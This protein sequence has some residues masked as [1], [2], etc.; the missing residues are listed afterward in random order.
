MVLGRAG[1]IA[2]LAITAATVE[3]GEDCGP[4]RQALTEIGKPNTA[5]ILPAARECYGNEASY[6]CVWVMASIGTAV[7]DFTSTARQIQACIPG[8]QM[9]IESDRRAS[10]RGSSH[11]ALMIRQ[12][13][14][15]SIIFSKGD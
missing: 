12:G 15:I 2:L 14:E 4:I 10:I 13:A 8:S 1:I 9:H 11:N 5:F 7:S 3:A 6:T